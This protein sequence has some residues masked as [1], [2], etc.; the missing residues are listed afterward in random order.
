MSS[1]PQEKSQQ[2]A[3]RIHRLKGVYGRRQEV[4][5]PGKGHSKLRRQMGEGTEMGICKILGRKEF[6]YKEVGTEGGL[7]H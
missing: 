7:F 1:V 3:L 5:F 4:S 6:R 2:T